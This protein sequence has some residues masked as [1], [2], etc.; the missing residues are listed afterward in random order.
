MDNEDTHMD[1]M[2]YGVDDVDMGTTTTRWLKQTGIGAFAYGDDRN[3]H[4]TLLFQ[5]I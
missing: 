1:V 3:A 4:S 2:F 5:L